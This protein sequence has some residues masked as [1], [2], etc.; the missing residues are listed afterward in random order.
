MRILLLII[1]FFGACVENKEQKVQVSNAN[2]TNS[3]PNII[4]DT[5]FHIM[6]GELSNTTFT[7]FNK[8]FDISQLTPYRYIGDFEH[9]SNNITN[10][11]SPS[12][13]CKVIAYTNQYGMLFF[14]DEEI[15]FTPDD[16]QKV[17]YQI[18][19][20][21]NLFTGATNKY[22]E[23]IKHISPISNINLIVQTF[24]DS[25]TY[26]D[27]STILEEIMYVMGIEYDWVRTYFYYTPDFYYNDQIIWFTDEF[28]S[29]LDNEVKAHILYNVLKT[30]KNPSIAFINGWLYFILDS[31]TPYHY[32]DELSTKLLMLDEAPPK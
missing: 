26:K 6:I 16:L 15:L 19:I 22:N 24:N 25:L 14:N 28:T 9:I 21:E 7:A 13:K 12:H 10:Y 8:L 20:G 23:I 31:F 30:S 1:L 17:P 11:T 27:D 5:M 3:H 18:L 32:S 4:N 29:I 2:P